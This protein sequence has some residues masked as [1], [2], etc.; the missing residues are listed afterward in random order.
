VP[1]GNSSKPIEQGVKQ[2]MEGG[3]LPVMNSWTSGHALRRQLPRGR[4]RRNGVQIAAS[5]G[6]KEAARKASPVLLEP[7]HWSRSWSGG[8]H[9]SDHRRPEL[10]PG[11]IEG[12]E[13][14]PARTVIKSLVPLAR[15]SGYATHM[16]SSTQGRAT[17]SM[18]FGPLR[19]KRR[20]R[21][22]RDHRQGTGQTAARV[23]RRTSQS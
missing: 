3:V 21:D 15:C 16:R 14:A 11:R 5:M 19:R 17:F 4:F 8:L 9:G 6:F 12:V 2:A 23:S 18:H 22:R 1:D 20:A 7:D 10:A 13:A